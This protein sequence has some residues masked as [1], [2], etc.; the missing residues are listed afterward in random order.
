MDQ[1][2]QA[3]TPELIQRETRSFEFTSLIRQE[4][5]DMRALVEDLKD[6]LGPI[7]LTHPSPSPL[8]DPEFLEPRTAE[9]AKLSEL[10]T[11]ARDVSGKMRDLMGEIEL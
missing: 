5:V 1:K 3:K 4:L 9:Q 6:K 2:A 10:L 11:I 8:K 7:T